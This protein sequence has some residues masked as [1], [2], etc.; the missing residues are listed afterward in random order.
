MHK[1]II[2][3][4]TILIVFDSAC[5]VG[6]VQ[7]IDRGNKFFESGQYA[8][9][10]IN[11]RKAVQKDPK[12]GEAYYR[13]GTVLLREAH[14][15]EAYKSL[16]V[17]AGSLPGRHDV[18]VALADASFAAYLRNPRAALYYETEPLGSRSQPGRFIQDHET[19]YP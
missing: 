14:A 8:D 15:D 10:E 13:L 6:P 17:A 7:Y 1:R 2:A 3:G 12:L 18:A 4:I 9:A 5:G 16:V 19:I 11:Y